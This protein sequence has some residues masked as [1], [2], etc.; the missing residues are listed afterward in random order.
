MADENSKEVLVLVEKIAEKGKIV[1][2]V[3]EVTKELER[4]KAKLVVTA[5]DVDPKEILMHLPILCKEK[6]VPYLEV[7]SKAELGKSANLPVNCSAIG[8][9]DLG[10]L[11]AEVKKV[12]GAKK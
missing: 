8:I 11:D 4:G 7:S 10:G 5:Q 6:G 12:T 9:T 2:G 1:K 3:N